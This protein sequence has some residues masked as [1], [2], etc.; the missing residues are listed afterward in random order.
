MSV[1]AAQ[2][3]FVSL[4]MSVTASG[5]VILARANVQTAERVGSTDRLLISL[6]C[7]HTLWYNIMSKGNLS[8][9]Y[10]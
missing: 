1:R 10:G 6:R 4:V 5:V 9:H 8:K 7:A 2:W 3:R